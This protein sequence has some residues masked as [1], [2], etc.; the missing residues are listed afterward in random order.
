MA[1]QHRRFG[2]HGVPVS[3]ACLGTMNSILLNIAVGSGAAGRPDDTT[4]FPQ[5]MHVDRVRV[6]KPN[7]VA[8][9]AGTGTS[10]Q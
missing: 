6:C 4:R 5:T 9:G 1:V 8:H 10:G 7:G 3:D 2:K